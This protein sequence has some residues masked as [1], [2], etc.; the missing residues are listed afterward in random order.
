[1]GAFASA[2]PSS[3][4]RQGLAQAFIIGREF[5]GQDAVCLILGDNIFFGQS[6]GQQLRRASGREQGATVF[7]YYV[8]DPK[9]YGVV[10]FDGGGKAVSSRGETHGA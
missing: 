5:V 8:S 10:A 2:T 4:R 3:P 1:M 6:F 9:R 7:G